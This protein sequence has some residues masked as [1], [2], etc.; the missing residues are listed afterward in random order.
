[1]H[2]GR[3]TTGPSGEANGRY[4][5]GGDTK[6]AIADRKAAALALGMIAQSEEG[7]AYGIDWQLVVPLLQ[8]LGVKETR[9]MKRARNKAAWNAG[10]R[11]LWGGE[12]RRGRH[13]R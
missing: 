3:K 4:R 1:M 7:A 12:D 6:R 13:K 9:E 11:R 10:D 2:G 5:H 8:A